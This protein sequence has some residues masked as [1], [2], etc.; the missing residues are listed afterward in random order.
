VSPSLNMYQSSGTSDLVTSAAY[1]YDGDSDLTDLTYYANSGHTGA[2]LAAYHWDYNASGVVTDE[3]SR[4][5]TSGTIGSSYSSWAE[6]SYTY[7]ASAELTGATYS[8]NFASAPADY[9]A[10]YDAN[11]NCTSNTGGDGTSTS[12]VTEDSTSNRLLFDGTYYYSY[13]ADGNRV[14][15]YQI[16][17]GTNTS[18]GTQASPNSEAYD[19]TIYTWNNA[20]ELTSATHYNTYSDYHNGTYTQ[21]NEYAIT[22]GND[23]FGQMVTRTAVTGDGGTTTTATQNYIYSG[24]NIVLVLDQYGDVLQRNLTGPAAGQVFASETVIGA[25]GGGGEDFEIYDWSDD[26]V[27]WYLTDNQGTVRDVA[28]YGSGVVDHLVYGAFGQL[29]SQSATSAGDQPTF[30]YNGTWQDPQTG[31]NKIGARWYDAADAVF[32]N[33]LGAPGYQGGAVNPYEFDNNT[34][35]AAAAGFAPASRPMNS[36]S[37]VGLENPSSVDDVVDTKTPVTQPAGTI[38]GSEVDKPV[39]ATPVAPLGNAVKHFRP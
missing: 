16:T 10:D 15:Q 9:S 1:G 35:T 13:D 25:Y 18:L 30:Y 2:P 38:P 33:C 6:T 12:S 21:T 24:Q 3:Y 14:A 28:R 32:A 5:D 8:T 27:N 11:G 26:T 36:A 37:P 23:A 20:N 17:S 4:K 29:V 39:F 19:I 34:P 22:Y 31:L 7:D